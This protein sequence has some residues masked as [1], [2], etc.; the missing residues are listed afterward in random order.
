MDRLRIEPAETASIVTCLFSCISCISWFQKSRPEV[1]V[2]LVHSTF[3]IQTGEAESL[4]GSY[5]HRLPKSSGLRKFP[6]KT[7]Q[8]GFGTN[9]ATVAVPAGLWEVRRRWEWRVRELDR[10]AGVRRYSGIVASIRPAASLNH[11]WSEGGR[12]FLAPAR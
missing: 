3:P 9:P 1:G 6:L 4:G 8:G 11:T 7:E 2:C 10:Q 12:W 5:A